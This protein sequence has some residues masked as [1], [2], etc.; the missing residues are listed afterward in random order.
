MDQASI[1]IHNALQVREREANL[2]LQI[3]ELQIRI[4]QSQK[5]KEV[6]AVISSDYFK[7]LREQADVLRR[8]SS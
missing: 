7:E 1:A 5:K 8:V 3:R 2:R 4:D 6:D